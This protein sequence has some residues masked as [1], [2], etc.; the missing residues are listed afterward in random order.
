MASASGALTSIITPTSSPALPN[1]SLSLEV[2]ENEAIVVTAGQGNAASEY[3]IRCLPSD[4]PGLRTDL[5]SAAGTPTPGYYLVG[6]SGDPPG[7]A[8][9]LNGNGVPIWYAENE[10]AGVDDVDDVVGGAISY[11][12]TW[13]TAPASIV[14]LNPLETS[15]V[16]PNGTELDTHELRVLPNGHYLAFS[17]VVVPGVN[18]TG[19]PNL[20]MPKGG[21][22]SNMTDCKIVEFEPSSGKVAWSWTF[23]EHFDPVT[24]SIVPEWGMQ[25]GVEAADVWHCNSIDV[26]QTNGN[27]LVSARNMD[28]VFYVDKA[29]AAVLWK[30]GGSKETK[31]HAVYVPLADP[32]HQQHDARLQP[33]WSEEQ[34]GGQISVFDDESDESAPARGLLLDVS[35][36]VNGAKAGATVAWQYKAQGGSA[37]RGSFRIDADG[38]RVIGWGLNAVNGLVFTELDSKGTDI[39]DFYFP[40]G[41]VSYRAIKIPTSAFDLGVLRR[42]A[43]TL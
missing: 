17:Y 10:M 26:D 14:H 9:L 18:L 29:T 30:M 7:Y 23:S 8:I 4:F 3:W 32:F 13:L 2:N 39:L 15:H 43:G 11:F 31:D 42:T 16:A 35:I 20:S 36:G 19:I 34:G 38:S 33:G 40:D 12:S 41:H 24:D 6:N 21:P 37:D 1:Q 22:D 28:S 5:H 27:L 25:S